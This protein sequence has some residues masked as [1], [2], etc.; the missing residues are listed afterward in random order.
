M[1]GGRAAYEAFEAHHEELTGDPAASWEVEG[2]DNRA[3]WEA[4][5]QAAIEAGGY[6][7]DSVVAGSGEHDV[8]EIVV[9]ASGERVDGLVGEVSQLRALVAEILGH[10]VQTSPT[11]LRVINSLTPA[12]AAKWRERAG[13]TVG[14][15]PALRAMQAQLAAEIS[16][17]VT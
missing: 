7:L 14:D 10:F 9:D 13:L 17:T 12:K 5:A 16:E 2:D 6:E 4:A 3:A 8:L 11:S 1:A 15:A